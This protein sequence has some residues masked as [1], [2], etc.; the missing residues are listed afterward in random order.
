MLAC[1]SS[2]RFDRVDEMVSPSLHDPYAQ[3]L[4]DSLVTRCVL[5]YPPDDKRVVAK[6]SGPGRYFRFSGPGFWLLKKIRSL[7]RLGLLLALSLARPGNEGRV[8]KAR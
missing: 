7:A 6:S 1:F 2:L 8:I 4:P 5:I 3:S